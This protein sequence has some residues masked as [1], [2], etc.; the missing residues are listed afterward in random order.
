MGRDFEGPVIRVVD[1]VT[2]YGERRIL[3]HVN[4]EVEAGETMVILGGSGTG[5]STLLRH[6]IRL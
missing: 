5:K 3:N 1:L 4:L 6:I 2:Y